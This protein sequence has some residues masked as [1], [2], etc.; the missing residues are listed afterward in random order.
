MSHVNYK[1]QVAD[2][3]QHIFK[4][5]ISF[6]PE[7]ESDVTLSLPNWLPGSYMIRDF[8]KH[9]LDFRAYDSKGSLSVSPE[10]KSSYRVSHNNLPVTV[11]YH[12][13][14]FDLSVRKAYLDQQ[15]GFINPA[16]SCYEVKGFGHTPCHVEI[17]K[18]NHPLTNK[19]KVAT[20]LTKTGQ[21]QSFDWGHYEAKN[22]LDFTDYPIL[23]GELDIAEFEVDQVP[24]YMVTAGKHF[25]SLE[26]V[27]KDLKP[28][29]EFQKDV[30]GGLPSD[31]DQYLFMTMVTD[32]GF[33]GLE[34]LNSTALVCSRHDIIKENDELNDNYQTFLSLCSHEYFHTWNVKRLKPEEFIPYDLNQEVYTEQLWFYEGMTS[35]F[36]DYSLVATNTIS[37]EKYLNTLAKSLT[38]VARG[39]GQTR[40]ALTES[41]YFSWTKFYQQDHTA[42][43]QITS[44]YVKGAA[45]ACFADLAIRAN[46]D[47]KLTLA[48]VMREA[49]QRWGQNNLGTSQAGLE[50]LFA[51][52]LSQN[53]F[54][55]FIEQLHQPV[56]FDVVEV[57]EKFGVS[58]SYHHQQKQNEWFKETLMDSKAEAPSTCKP[59][60]Q[61]PMWFGAIV[62]VENGAVVVKQV[63][64]N[65]PAQKAGIAVG[66]I[67]V[68]L[69]NTKI[70]NADLETLMKN[71]AVKQE[72]SYANLIHYFRKDVLLCANIELAESPKFVAQ[73]AITNKDK[74]KAWLG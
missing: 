65:S 70:A 26:R 33:G 51:K 31:V 7:S 54:Q 45:L 69:N 40:Q 32:N 6:T 36:D 11:E 30:F 19:W 23:M 56:R 50:E 61:P 29:C 5:E 12:Y 53:D 74:L 8:A 73:F 25:G 14:A 16:S 59:T 20:G 39:E 66:D 58:L 44:Y 9:V 68:A 15:F 48:D 28:I 21:T 46:S 1:I 18:P 43:D 3:L 27:V 24:H 22:Y 17:V 4:I 13:Y 67:L 47:N 42:P 38:R 63:L 57:F 37:L 62:A 52:Y 10:S 71:V 34:H 72:K 55:T 49:W 60:D 41:S 64:N 2:P 35:Y